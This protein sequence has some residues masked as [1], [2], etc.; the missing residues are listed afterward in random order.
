MAPPPPSTD[1]KTLNSEPR[2]GRRRRRARGRSACRGGPSRSAHRL[3]V[4]HARPRRGAAGR[5]RAAR[6]PRHHG[7]HRGEHV[8][9]L[10]EGHLDVE[11]GELG[12]AVGAQV[13]V[14]EAA[15]DLVVALEAGDH[16]QLLE[17]LRGLRQRVA[18]PGAAGSGRGSRARPRAST[19]SGSAS[20][21]R[22][23]RG[24][25]APRA[26]CVIRRAAPAPRACPRGAGRAC[27]AAGVASRRRRV[28]VDREGR[29]LG[30]A[31]RSIGDL[32]LDLAG[33]DVRV[34]VLRRARTT[35]PAAETT[36]SGRRRSASA[37]ASPG[38]RVEDEL[39]DPSG[40]AGR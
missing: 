32:D 4:G 36:C 12:L 16:K 38:L 26:S 24:R 1:S 34:H 11:L 40:R 29:R 14:A 39:H 37:N 25:R 15:G 8:V 33:G 17:E 6:R 5:G 7:L 2:S 21:S 18:V 22:G 30:L 28:L 27:G 23:S 9:L 10:D 13:L 19:G 35:S 20:R 31:R 3:G